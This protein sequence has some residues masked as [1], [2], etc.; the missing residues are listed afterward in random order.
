VTELNAILWRQEVGAG[1]LVLGSD[2][3]ERTDAEVN[4]DQR[5]NQAHGDEH[6]SNRDGRRP[7]GRR[8][9]A[10]H[11]G[12]CP[13]DTDHKADLDSLSRRCMV[14]KER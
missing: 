12:G 1:S 7:S 6:T 5:Q 3:L 2:G 8:D 11:Q 9:S 4:R 13:K 14:E 10:Y